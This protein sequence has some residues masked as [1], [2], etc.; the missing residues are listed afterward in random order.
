MVDV[1][2]GSGL[3]K[4][5]SVNQKEIPVM[6]AG[7]ISAYSASPDLENS[8]SVDGRFAPYTSAHTPSSCSSFT[9]QKPRPH[10]RRDKM[11]YLSRNNMESM[12][13]T[14]FPIENHPSFKGVWEYTSENLELSRHAIPASSSPDLMVAPAMKTTTSSGSRNFGP[15]PSSLEA[16]AEPLTGTSTDAPAN[17]MQSMQ[18][19][20]VDWTTSASFNSGPDTPS[21]S[22][23]FDFPD[24][25][26]QDSPVYH[27][28][29]FYAHDPSHAASKEAPLEHDG[30]SQYGFPI[31]PGGNNEG[32]W[33]VWTAGNDPD[34][35]RQPYIADGMT[36]E[37]TWVSGGYGWPRES[38][39]TVVLRD[40]P[41][42]QPC[43]PYPQFSHPLEH[44]NIHHLATPVAFGSD[45][46]HKPPMSRPLETNMHLYQ[47]YT[48]AN[49]KSQHT[50]PLQSFDSSNADYNQPPPSTAQHDGQSEHV[51]IKAN[52]HYSDKRNS[53]LI[54]FKRR[55]LSYK[56]IKRIGG[57]KEAESTLRG[58]YRTLTKT[59]DQ[60]VRKP[61]WQDRDVSIYKT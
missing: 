58:R 40:S 16:V 55:G 44:H 41:A 4:S 43:E 47:G 26:K 8:F 42:V 53:F 14:Q 36:D 5:W 38:N 28:L 31:I 54:E 49:P 27:G 13:H 33:G 39:P 61:K 56:D 59:K 34:P 37:Q 11:Q 9:H 57:F 52:L 1:L 19:G 2:V 45:T 22:S 50:Y 6:D 48:S 3:P 18:L 21:I 35:W 10:L 15:M 23:S 60:R 24:V 20:E 7:F 32:P 12:S 30:S 25:R 29:P 51:G 46:D 17:M